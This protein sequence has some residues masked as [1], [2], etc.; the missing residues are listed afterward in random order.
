MGDIWRTDDFSIKVIAWN[1]RF[2]GMLQSKETKISENVMHMQNSQKTPSPIPSSKSARNHIERFQFI[3]NGKIKCDLFEQVKREELAEDYILSHSGGSLCIQVVLCR[4]IF[5]LTGYHSLSRILLFRHSFVPAHDAGRIRL[6]KHWKKKI[7]K[8]LRE[9]SVR[10]D[11]PMKKST[12]RVCW[13]N[14][15]R[16]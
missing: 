5:F 13:E 12:P 4:R 7:G 6:F 1:R 14:K 16:C 9:R 2:D 8:V 15:T 3:L 10:A 11:S